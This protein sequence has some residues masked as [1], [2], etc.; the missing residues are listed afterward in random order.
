MT[1]EEKKLQQVIKEYAKTVT[2]EQKEKTKD[3]QQIE[4][5]KKDI[6][7]NELVSFWKDEIK[8]NSYKK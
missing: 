8:I 3:E 1:Q 7:E 6:A 5:L 4:Q 2:K